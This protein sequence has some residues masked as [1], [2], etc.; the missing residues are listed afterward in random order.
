VVEIPSFLREMLN[1]HVTTYCSSDPDALVFTAS[2]GSPMRNS[3]FSKNVWKPAVEGSGVHKGLRI[4]D[5]RH[6]SVAL[7]ISLGAHPE[8]IKQHLGHSSIMVTMD[9][10]GH[11]FPSRTRE[12]ADAL[13]GLYRR[14]QTDKPRTKSDSAETS[15]KD[16]K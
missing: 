8:E 2:N 12:L 5:L 9:I 1:H 14:N 16:G 10:Y 11:L 13:D 3:N 15:G 4:H 6:T 7:L